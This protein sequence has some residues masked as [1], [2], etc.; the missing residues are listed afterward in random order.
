ML[1]FKYG[2]EDA[3]WIS[4]PL[5]NAI[6]FGAP[7]AL[8]LLLNVIFLVIT[9]RGLTAGR[10][11]SKELLSSKMSSVKEDFAMYMVIQKKP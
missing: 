6:V 11:Q 4:D 10:K 8:S 3:C 2:S 9:I 5:A 7:V 1:S